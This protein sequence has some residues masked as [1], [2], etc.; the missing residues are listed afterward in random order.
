MVFMRGGNNIIS[1]NKFTLLNEN[2][3]IIEEIE[4]KFNY[5]NRKYEGV[6]DIKLLSINDEIIFTGT[7]YKSIEKIGIAR[8]TYS[9]E[10]LEYKE[11]FIE[12]ENYCEKKLGIFT[13]WPKNDI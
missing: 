8:G 13:L 9:K 10:N 4:P 6:E 1:I 12:N 7:C 3:E 11:L 5:L 2:L